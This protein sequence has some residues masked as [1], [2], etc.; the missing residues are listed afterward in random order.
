MSELTIF[1]FQGNEVRTVELDGTTWFVAGDVTKILG[2]GGGARNAIARLPERMKGVAKINTLGGVQQVTVVNEAGLNRLIMRSNV[3]GAERFQ[4]WIA[5]EVLPSIRKTG[6]YG[7]APALT[8]P[9][10]LA[11]AVIEAQAMIE[12]KDAHIAV[13]APKASRYD[14][15]LGADGDY[16]LRDAAQ[17]LSRDHG[18]KIGQNNLAK[19]MRGNGWIDRRGIPYQHRIDAGH[20]RAKPRTYKHPR[21]GEDVATDPQVRITPRGLD[22]LAERLAGPKLV[23]V[24]A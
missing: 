11:R 14:A 22:L 2:Y 19:W 6:G 7:Q 16:P 13:L 18:I 15:F 8:G 1:D 23:E 9:E 5:E 4:D 12:A 21:T 10:L 17:I 24:G 3:E 20:L